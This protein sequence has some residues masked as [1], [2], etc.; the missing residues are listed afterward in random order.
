[1]QFFLKNQ[2]ALKINFFGHFIKFN[3]D[4]ALQKKHKKATH[5]TLNQRAVTIMMENDE[6]EDPATQSKPTGGDLK[7]NPILQEVKEDLRESTSSFNTG[8]G[9][10]MSNFQSKDSENEEALNGDRSPDTKKKHLR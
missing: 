1:M 7:L 3:L 10:G 2:F 4:G 5:L 8:F 9:F 6:D